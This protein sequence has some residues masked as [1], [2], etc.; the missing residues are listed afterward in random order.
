MGSGI[1]ADNMLWPEDLIDGNAG[2]RM[3]FRVVCC[4]SRFPE[5]LES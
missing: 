5:S 2:N 1:T 3:I 4:Q